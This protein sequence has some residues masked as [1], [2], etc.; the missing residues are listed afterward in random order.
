[1]QIVEEHISL[2]NAHDLDGIMAT[3][4]ETARYD[5]E[6][7]GAHYVGRE[8]VREFYAQ[9]LL[10]IPDLKIEV[11]R[12]HAAEEAVVLEV[13]IRGHHL[14]TW[15]GLAATGRQVDFPLCGIFTFDE[16]ERL[17]GE[18]I[19]YDRAT[20]LGQLGVLHDPQSL[21]GRISTALVHPITMAQIA[22][23]RAITLW[24]KAL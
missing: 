9:M 5:D 3:F 2:E 24:K 1:L 14:G 20:L 21:R 22:A 15:R 11:R 19:Y 17:A 18:K 4:G 8:E 13:A 10:A 7:W 23:R 12:R 6:G 16:R